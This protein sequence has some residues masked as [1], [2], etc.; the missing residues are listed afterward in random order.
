MPK[1]AIVLGASGLV[2]TALVHQ[3]ID[4]SNY[5]QIRLIVRRKLEIKS[6]KVEQIV[7]NF[8]QPASYK[9]LIVGDVLF[10]T[11]GTTIKKA[12]SKDAQYKIDFT[13][14]YEVA[15]AAF[16]NGVGSYVLISS[17]GANPDS[18]NFYSRMKGELDSAVQLL[19]FKKLRIIRPSILDGHR[20]EKRPIEQVMLKVTNLILPHIPV[21]RKYRPIS[22]EIVAKAMLNSL[23]LPKQRVAIAELE[24]VFD[25]AR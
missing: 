21:L 18:F 13:Y 22:V 14:Q 2:G 11:F 17:A 3:L 9:N 25:W 24:E 6:S 7:V 19:D 16:E 1:T 20:M 4:S 15:K 23:S 5:D 10:S 8:D 12:G